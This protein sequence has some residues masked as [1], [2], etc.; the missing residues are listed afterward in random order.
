MNLIGKINKHKKIKLSISK[1]KVKH[2]FSVINHGNEGWLGPAIKDATSNMIASQTERVD[3]TIKLLNQVRYSVLQGIGIGIG[4]EILSKLW[5]KEKIRFFEIIKKAAFW[6]I[7]FGVK[8]LGVNVLKGVVE[9]GAI[10]FIP[11]TTES[12]T[13]SNLSYIIIEN[14]KI[15]CSAILGR[16]KRNKCFKTMEMTTLEIILGIIISERGIKAGYN[17]GMTFGY[18]LAG[19]L[20]FLGGTI[21]YIIGFKIAEIILNIIDSLCMEEKKI[22]T[23]IVR[24]IIEAIKNIIRELR[25]IF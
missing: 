5:R 20:G 12:G 22:R 11:S 21:G 24:E 8:I 15:L 25:V 16:L 6:G 7:D 2:G 19:A 4:I 18:I 10:A 14:I 13:I 23:S 17:I 9:S 1:S 3:D